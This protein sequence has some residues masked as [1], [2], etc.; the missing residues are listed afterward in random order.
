MKPAWPQRLNGCRCVNTASYLMTPTTKLKCA[1][2]GGVCLKEKN[3][4]QL[5]TRPWTHSN[6]LKATP[7]SFFFTFFLPGR[8]ESVGHMLWLIN[9]RSN[10][11]QQSVSDRQHMS[12]YSGVGVLHARRSC[13]CTRF[14][15]AFSDLFCRLICFVSL[16]ISLL[17]D[18]CGSNGASIFARMPSQNRLLPLPP[19]SPPC[20]ISRY[21]GPRLETRRQT[22][23]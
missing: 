12:G 20:R 18:R 8:L 2:N 10:C 1:A 6:P 11:S 9:S 16:M 15:C 5:L 3:K 19:L 13:S 4:A 17:R 22:I 21:V 7:I 14:C 23:D